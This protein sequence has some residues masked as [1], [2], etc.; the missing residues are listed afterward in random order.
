MNFDRNI[1]S[2]SIDCS[3]NIFHN[4]FLTPEKKNNDTKGDDDYC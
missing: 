4:I 2:K 1:F 3:F